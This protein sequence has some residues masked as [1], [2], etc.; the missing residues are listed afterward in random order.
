VLPM[1]Q[2]LR[3]GSAWLAVGQMRASN[4]IEGN[5]HQCSHLIQLASD[6]SC[7]L[8]CLPEAFD[9]V[10]EGGAEEAQRLAQPLTGS[11]MTRYRDLARAHGIW[12][13]LG[14]FHEKIQ[15]DD[16]HLY[17][18]HVVVDNEGSIQG[19]Y[20]KLHLFDVA[21]PNGPV[22]QESKG[23]RAGSSM[24]ALDSPV[25]KLG[26]SVCYDLRFSELYV[27]YRQHAQAD[28]MLVPSAFTATT[29]RAHWQPLLRARAIE[30]Q[31]YVAAAA[32]VGR[33]NAKRES[34]GHA[35]I[36]DPWGE[37]VA[38]CGEKELGIAVAEV[39]LNYVDHIRATM[40][41]FSHRRSDLYGAIQYT[42]PSE[43]Q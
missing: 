40:P 32:Q 33:H 35:C 11:L 29:G 24:C 15:E 43:Q 34:Y 17:N 18:T 3:R 4:D 9:F 28:L 8:L 39:D 14:G 38:S 27:A 25:G 36:I 31:C 41:V 2:A 26:L 20:R 7:S 5:F 13:S 23:T 1:T 6:R 22:L 42:R 21:I 19:V 16:T 37:V 10:T 30:T 12:L